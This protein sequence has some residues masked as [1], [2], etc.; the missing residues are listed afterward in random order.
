MWRASDRLDAQPV[1]GAGEGGQP[2]FSPDGEWLAFRRGAALLK[3]AMR[4]GAPVSICDSCPGYG[5]SWDIDDTIRYH[6]IPAGN[7]LGRI[8]VAVP[9][10]GGRFRVL[11]VPDSGSGELFRS[12]QLLPDRRTLLFNLFTR[13]GGRIALLDLRSGRITRT[14]VAGIYPRWVEGGWIVFGSS[15]GTLATIPF[16]LGKLRATGPPVAIARDVIGDPTSVAAGISTDGTII[17]ARTGEVSDRRLVAVSRSGQVVDLGGEA[18]AYAHPRFSPDGR[19]VAV[20]I[21]GVSGDADVWILDLGQRSLSRL[22]TQRQAG[23][24]VWTPDGRYVIYSQNADIW[25]IAADG[26]GVP[27]SLLEAVG[28]RFAG[29][30]TPDGRTLVLQEEGSGSDG[31][32]VLTLDSS[33]AARTIIPANFREGAPSISPD[34]RWL[35]YQSEQSGRAEVYVRPFPE[36]G[37]RVQ[38]SLQG[39]AGPA[40]SRDGRELFYRSADSLIVATVATTPSF[41]VTGRRGLFPVTGYLPGDLS[42]RGY[43]VSPDGS[44]FVMVLGSAAATPMVALHG[45]FERLAYDIRRRR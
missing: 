15:D 35:A 17:Y 9:S 23:R 24:P 12:P 38:I 4:G 3:V 10:S 45:F 13:Q 37:A 39:G 40:W 11:A 28:S 33:R 29:N 2:F 14:D 1:S 43:D 8:L 20:G 27:D 7:P 41:T 42:G 44:R 32:R 16:D 25:R 36:L 34:G 6:T 21:T 5:Y 19:R 26:S 18:R 30:T 31:L 22:T